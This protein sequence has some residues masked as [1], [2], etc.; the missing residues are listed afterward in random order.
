M[1]LAIGVIAA[2][3]LLAWGGMELDHVIHAYPGQFLAGVISFLIIA[4][5]LA[6]AKFRLAAQR[7]PLRPAVPPLP[8]AIKAAP[9]LTA[10]ASPGAEDARECEGP[11]CRN[12]VDDDPWK[13][14]VP[15]DARHEFCSER[16]TRAWIAA[17]HPGARV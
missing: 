3:L 15:G 16:C 9:V 7:V 5:A 6:A 2:L 11:G 8:P 12:K 13:G 4:F 1:P 14:G 10:I 17:N